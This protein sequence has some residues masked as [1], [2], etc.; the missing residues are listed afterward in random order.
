MI[1]EERHKKIL[2]LI[3]IQNTVDVHELTDALN[4]SESTV[5]RDLIALS[6]MGKLKKVHGGAT[7]LSEEGNIFE[8]DFNTK[9]FLHIE[10]KRTI[11]KYAAQFI[12]DS[13]FVFIDAGTTTA[14]MIDFIPERTQATFVTNGIAHAKKLLQMGFK[15][16]IVG[17]RIKLTTEAVVGAECI[18]NM[19]KYNFTKAFIGTNGIDL[20]FGFTTPDVEEALVKSEAVG[21]AFVTYILSDGS[22]FEKTSAVTFAELNQCCIITDRAPSGE[23]KEKT[24][25]KEVML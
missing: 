11:G 2:E 7:A 18:N 14:A 19:R 4:V 22:K 8:P 10:E 3:K 21:R 5:R 12:Q 17:G 15:A 20:S 9:S 24:V 6:K 23:F 16:Y 25:I 1:T 13:D